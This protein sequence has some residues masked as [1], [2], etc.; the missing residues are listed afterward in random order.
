MVDTTRP[1]FLTSG[2]VSRQP[3]QSSVRKELVVYVPFERPVALMKATKLT[4]EQQFV[5]RLQEW[6]FGRAGIVA[7]VVSPRIKAK[8]ETV[9]D[10]YRN[11]ENKPDPTGHAGTGPA[12]RP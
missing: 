8:T 5:D 3:K 10:A 9:L 6:L 2:E 1:S 4:T 11:P 7:P 12:A